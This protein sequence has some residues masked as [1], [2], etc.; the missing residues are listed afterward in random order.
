MPH[1]ANPV[2]SADA[3]KTLG[4]QQLLRLR[5]PSLMDPHHLFR[6]LVV[7]NALFASL[8]W[9]L[10]RPNRASAISVLAFSFLWVAMD[11]P[12]ELEGR[13]LY[14]VSADHGITGS[15]LVSLFAVLVVSAQWLRHRMIRARRNKVVPTHADDTHAEAETLPIPKVTDAEMNAPRL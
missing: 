3:R 14:V 7:M 10:A 9:F 5:G 12:N 8:A 2:Q 13:I 11:K 1:H 6:S 4:E 15:D